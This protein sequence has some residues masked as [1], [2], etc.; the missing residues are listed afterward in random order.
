MA[1]WLGS[2]A[3]AVLASLGSFILILLMILPPES[4]LENKPLQIGHFIP[5]SKHSDTQSRSRVKAPEP[6]PQEQQPPTPQTPQQMPTQVT[7]EIKLD[8]AAPNIASAISIQAQ[9]MPALD[10]VAPA[11]AAPP[12]APAAPAAPQQASEVM[13]LNEVMPEYPDMARRR[14]IEGFVRLGFTIN[15]NGR[16]ENIEVLEASPPNVFDRSAR[17]AAARWRFTPGMENGIAV[18]RKAVKTIEFKLRQSR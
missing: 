4:R 10:V 18:P 13:P 12:A 7:P 11:P 6:P 8:L 16:V 2:F 15:A 1:R 14:G 5:M 17:R 9:P 3:V